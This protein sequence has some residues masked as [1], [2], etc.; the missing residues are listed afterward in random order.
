M[1][2]R[3][4]KLV[5][6]ASDTI[7]ARWRLGLFGA[8]ERS[9]GGQGLAVSLRGVLCWLIV[10]AVVG[11]V[12]AT[13][14]LFF[15]FDRKPGNLI[16][17]SDTLLLPL[18]RDAVR[19]LR[20]RMMITEGL[21]DLEARRW[22]EA[23]MKL[24]VGLARDPHNTIGRLALARFYLGA[25]RRP[26]ALEV[27]T[28]DL[29]HGNPGRPLLELLFSTAADGEDYEV[30]VRTCDRLLGGAT[31]ER[32]WLVSQR[33][34]AL[35]A[36][37]RAAEALDAASASGEPAD[38]LVREAR[39]LALLQLRRTTEALAELETWVA[40]APGATHPQILRLQVRALREAGRVDEMESAWEQLRE[41]TPNDPRTYVYGVVQKALAGEQA[42]AAAAL[43]RFF[44]RFSASQPDLMMAASAL[45]EAGQP[46]LVQRCAE[47]AAQ[48]G[49]PLC[50]M[51][52]VLLQAQVIAGDWPGATQTLDQVTPLPADAPPVEAFAAQWLE[53]LLQ[54]AAEADEGAQTR[55][56]EL[57]EQRPLPMR[58][59]R[60]TAEVLVKAGRFAGA[61]AVVQIAERAFP[62]SGSLAVLRERADVGR[63][64]A[65]VA[66]AAAMPAGAAAADE[67]E[68]FERLVQL[69]A[70]ER[71]SDAAQAIREIRVAKPAWL[72]ARE[73]DVFDWQMRVAIRTGDTLELLGA[74][75]L[76][77]D[78]RRE[79]AQRV[80]AL[81]RELG[82]SGSRD[83]AALLLNEVLRKNHAFPPALRLRKEWQQ[84]EPAAAAEPG[85]PQR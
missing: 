43:D 82:E 32:D 46:S 55:L 3:R 47:R 48:Q 37:N 78:G 36:A 81:A 74:A 30:I 68:F 69:T 65:P 72:A 10:L 53:R 44:L 67:R 26:Q 4:I 16:R 15:W 54:S 38:A 39:V 73:P 5:W 12:A 75:K 34:Q 33:L 1:S 79:S 31:S 17:Y 20:G 64:A 58:V 80:V 63:R 41:L 24:R 70:A 18:R 61:A 49:F 62:N 21:A 59:Y 56:T 28:A 23:V 45:L 35:L 83:T 25:N 76:F 27:L 13:T 14:A 9:H 42:S 7:R 6:G 85:A 52:L 66:T 19:E 84:T 77:L 60:Q 11:Y 40:N 71:W 51:Q 50:S 8:Y 22:S 29:A 2:S 57:L